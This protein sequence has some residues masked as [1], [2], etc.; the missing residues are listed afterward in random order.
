MYLI[1]YNMLTFDLIYISFAFSKA[2]VCG[3]FS[4]RRFLLTDRH[5]RPTWSRQT[6]YEIIET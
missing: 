2:Q 5:R 1:K 3:Y 4:H 6:S